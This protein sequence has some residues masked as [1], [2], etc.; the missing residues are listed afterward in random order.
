MA[1]ERQQ[2]LDAVIQLCRSGFDPD[3]PATGGAQLQVFDRATN[4]MVYRQP[5]DRIVRLD[6]DEPLLYVRQIVDQ[7]PQFDPE[8]CRRRSLCTTGVT[9]DGDRV[10]F[11]QPQPDTGEYAIILPADTDQIAMIDAF[12][13]WKLSAITAEEEIALDGLT[14]YG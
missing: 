10:T 9:V 5:I 1:G 3:G 4:Q 11:P 6:D 14:D 13:T 8:A 7:G 2:W 12:D